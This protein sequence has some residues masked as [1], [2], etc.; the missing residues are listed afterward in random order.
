VDLVGKLLASGADM[1]MGRSAVEHH[2]HLLRCYR[3][4]IHHR[5]MI[6]VKVNRFLV[7][8]TMDM[9]SRHHDSHCC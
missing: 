6:T 7:L 4:H 1:A 2:F 8:S 3:D 9:G 5:R